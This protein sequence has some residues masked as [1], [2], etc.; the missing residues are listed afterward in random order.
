MAT[1][2]LHSILPAMALPDPVTCGPMVFCTTK[3]LDDYRVQPAS[4][5][6]SIRQIAAQF[7]SAQGSTLDCLGLELIP[8]R[9]ASAV[10]REG[11]PRI[12]RDV[13]AF[14]HITGGTALNC[15]H[16][17][18]TSV[19]NS[20][21]F[22]SL[23]IRLR[24]DG[25]VVQRPG[26]LGFTHGLD[27]YQPALPT[28]L[29]APRETDFRLDKFLFG[30][31]ERA[32]TGFLRGRNRPAL[33]QLFRAI[34]ISLHATRIMPETE[35]TYHDLGTR[36]MNWVSAFETLVHAGRGHV[37]VQDVLKR[38]RRIDWADSPVS[39]PGRRRGRQPCISHARYV[40]RDRHGRCAGRENAACRLYRRLYK[41]RNDAAHGNMI[42]PQEFAARKG[43][44]RG[45]RIDE[46]A[47]LLF[48]E[49]VLERLRELRVIRRLPQ[50]N[51]SPRQFGE[52][53]K[54]RMD[55]S[56]FHDALAKA[57]LDVKP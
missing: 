49:C 17:Q 26:M 5:V 41:L 52:Y 51:L 13:V 50:G 32:M 34:A 56:H 2:H 9:S 44:R 24:K 21:Y 28:H 10:A 4:D 25:F 22:E 20:D 39:L 45:P 27:H 43:N 7:R 36:I 30:T 19:L 6:A 42:R 38:V 1:Y 31:F 54:Q 12:C 47:P 46:I 53:V 29:G 57:L 14:C 3:N 40:Y 11:I 35:S 18:A 33:R 55:A 48:R 23:P 16:G 37:G 8:A 15:Y